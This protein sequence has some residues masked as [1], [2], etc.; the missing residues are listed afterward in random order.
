MSATL[1]DLRNALRRRFEVQIDAEGKRIANGQA[2]DYAEYKYGC[3]IVQG[4]SRA[5]GGVDDIFNKVLNEN[6]DYQGEKNGK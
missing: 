6:D 5:L 3:G 2:K 1:M 4:L